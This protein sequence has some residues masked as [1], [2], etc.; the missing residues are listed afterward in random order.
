M[1]LIG[2]VIGVFAVFG[3][4]V[5]LIGRSIG[6]KQIDDW[7]SQF[8]DND[9]YHCYYDRKMRRIL[10]A[11]RRASLKIKPNPTALYYNGEK[12]QQSKAS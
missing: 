6:W 11:Q 10:W 3:L 9:G 5:W 4:A 12:E 7:N 8:I 2:I 1:L